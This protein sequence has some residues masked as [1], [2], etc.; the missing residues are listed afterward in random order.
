MATVP[1]KT[2]TAAPWLTDDPPPVLPVPTAPPAT[3]PLT[4]VLTLTRP[5]AV[6][7]P[8]P[9]PPTLTPAPTAPTVSPPAVDPPRTAAEDT[10]PVLIDPGE[11]WKPLCESKEA[12]VSELWLLR[13]PLE[14]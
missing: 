5:L 7:P 13:E 8:L 10:D 6:D 14:L 11:L 1:P 2:P 4:L 9:A 3:L 12:P